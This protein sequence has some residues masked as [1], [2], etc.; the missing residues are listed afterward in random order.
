MVPY[1]R[2]PTIHTLELSP[3]MWEYLLLNVWYWVYKNG[4][5]K[6]LFAM[7]HWV[8]PQSIQPSV[9]GPHNSLLLLKG[10]KWNPLIPKK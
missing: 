3:K 8:P 4:T 5:I 7:G 9:V 2:T 6:A 1:I 10:T